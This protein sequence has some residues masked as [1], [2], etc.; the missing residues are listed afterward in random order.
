MERIAAGD[1]QVMSAGTGI[2]CVGHN[3]EQVATKI[4]I[5]II[6]DQLGERPALATR[7]FPKAGCNGRFVTLASGREQDDGALPIRTDA[8]VVGAALKA[9]ETPQYLM[10]A[11]RKGYLV[12]ATGAVRIG[13]I[14]VG[15]RDGA[16]IANVELLS[17]AAIEDSV[18]VLA[19]AA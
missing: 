5:W 6:P 16:A 9:G 15:A 8:R 18:I 17:V 14:R 13:N 4:Q 3:H 10:G 19:D 2:A 11:D 12:P 1:V 7:P